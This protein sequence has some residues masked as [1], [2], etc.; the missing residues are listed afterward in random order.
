MFSPN[1]TP[2]EPPTRTTTTNTNSTAASTPRNYARRASRAI[3]GDT[4]NLVLS[5]EEKFAQL[6]P[7]VPSE[8]SV[9]VVSGGFFEGRVKVRADV[10]WAFADLMTNANPSR[11]GV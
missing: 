4:P 1:D 9:N 2:E 5:Q 3:V 10:R 7:R 8:Y 11:F 6:R